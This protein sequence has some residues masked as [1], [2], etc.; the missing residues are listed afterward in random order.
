[1]AHSDRIA[2]IFLARQGHHHEPA[3]IWH[4]ISSWCATILVGSAILFGSPGAMAGPTNPTLEEY[5]AMVVIRQAGVLDHQ[6]WTK[7]YKAWLQGVYD[8]LTQISAF[9]AED[10]LPHHVFCFNGGLHF[11]RV[12]PPKLRGWIDRAFASGNWSKLRKV[13]V[14]EA[15]FQIYLTSAPC[16]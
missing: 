15:I 4:R 10:R 12:T 16:R 13:R 7:S 6:A 9:R 2:C 3:R 8:T 11:S 14:S 5:Q 1:M